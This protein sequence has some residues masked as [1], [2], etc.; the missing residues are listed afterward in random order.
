[1]PSKFIALIVYLF[2]ASWP[3]YRLTLAV[4][5]EL[6][7]GKFCRNPMHIIGNENGYKVNDRGKVLEELFCC[8]ASGG[9]DS[10]SESSS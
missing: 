1:M 5:W 2:I 9:E 7:Y 6:H 8:E 10:E 3:I 4:V